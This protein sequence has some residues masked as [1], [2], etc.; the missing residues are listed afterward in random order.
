M[1][2]P[3]RLPPQIRPGQ[4]KFKCGD[5]RPIPR[6]PS[7]QGEELRIYCQCIMTGAV[8]KLRGGINFFRFCGMMRQ[9]ASCKKRA[10]SITV[11]QTRN[12]NNPS[13]FKRIRGKTCSGKNG[14][15]AG[16]NLDW[17]FIKFNSTPNREN[18][19]DSPTDT[20]SIDLRVICN[21]YVRIFIERFTTT[22]FDLLPFLKQ[23]FVNEY[24]LGNILIFC[25]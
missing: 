14:G 5:K 8:R 6:L 16:T 20:Y 21:L 11:E 23:Y 22:L 18:L 25:A 3:L 19:S 9:F 1:Q 7:P 4:S 12:P 13:N 10:Q 2:R 24:K 15:G 17:L